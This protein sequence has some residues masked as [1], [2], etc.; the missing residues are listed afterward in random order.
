MIKVVLFSRPVQF[1]WKLKLY[2]II[3]SIFDYRIPTL[4]KPSVLPESVS[5]LESFDPVTDAGL[6]D[7]H[8][9]TLTRRTV[10]TS[11]VALLRAPSSGHRQ[12]DGS[13]PAFSRVSATAKETRTRFTEKRVHKNIKN[14]EKYSVNEGKKKKKKQR[15]ISSYECIKNSLRTT[16]HFLSWS[17]ARVDIPSASTVDRNSLD[18]HGCYVG[19]ARVRRRR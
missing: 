13:G 10:R 8:R 4:G 3:W 12:L 1:S 17:R 16:V 5:S 14:A 15:Q 7:T 11:F 6:L 18:S 2:R 9:S 19:L